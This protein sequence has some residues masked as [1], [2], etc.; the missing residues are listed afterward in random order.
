MIGIADSAVEVAELVENHVFEIGLM[1][2]L[3]EAFFEVDGK[4]FVEEFQ[5]GID[6]GGREGDQTEVKD[7]YDDRNYTS[8]KHGKVA[9]DNG[10]DD[11]PVDGGDV[12]AEEGSQD[13]EHCEEEEIHDLLA[14]PGGDDDVDE[15][16][17]AFEE[18]PIY[19]A[20]AGLYWLMRT[21]LL[22]FLN[23][24]FSV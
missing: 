9:L 21:L 4:T 23:F 1:E 13:Q 7:L 10:F 11:F 24:M 19:V 5:E 18:D 8:D 2:V 3:G 12:D 17:D 22:S 6:E 14:L 15:M 20:F 16:F